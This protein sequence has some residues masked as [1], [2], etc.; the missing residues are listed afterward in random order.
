ME[1]GRLGVIK[2]PPMMVLL[3]RTRVPTNGRKCFYPRM[4]LNTTYNTQQLLCIIRQYPLHYRIGNFIIEM[5]AVTC[6]SFITL[7]PLKRSQH[8]GVGEQVRNN[9]RD[10]QKKIQVYISVKHFSNLR[11]IYATA[12]A[13]FF[14]RSHF[15]HAVL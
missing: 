15:T 8:L 6:Q 10:I 4:Y 11:V 12:F 5:T 2:I 13:R 14:N 1:V 9:G 3:N 7:I